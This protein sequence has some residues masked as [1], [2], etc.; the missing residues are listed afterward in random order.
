MSEFSLKERLIARFL[1]RFPGVKRYVKNV[2]V[3][4]N[5]YIYKKNYLS[6][7]HCKE[8][9]DINP[10]AANIDGED[11][12]GY[13][14]KLP[15]NKDGW[16]L[17]HQS[18]VS[19]RED[20]D[21]DKDI[22]IL[23]SNIYSGEIL[24]I[25]S[26]LSY[27]WQQGCR[28]QWIDDENILFNSVKENKYVC[29]LYS[30]KERKILNVF[31]YPVQDSYGE[32]FLSIDYSNLAKVTKDYGYF[33]N[34]IVQD[35]YAI[36][37]VDIKSGNSEILLDYKEIIN[38]DYIEE[39][40]GAFHT[41]NHIM[42]SPEGDK[43]IFIHRYYIDGVRYDRLMLYNLYTKELKVLV[44]DGMVSHCCWKTNDIVFGYMRV[45]NT[46][47]YYEIS[48]N[49]LETYFD[50]DINDLRVGDGHPSING[51]YLFFDTYPDKSR[52]QKIFYKLH[53]AKTPVL[54]LEVFSHPL[55]KESSRC[56]L[57]PRYDHRLGLLFFDSVFKGKRKQ[58]YINVKNL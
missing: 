30:I 31:N 16:V 53:S 43:F 25:G 58:Y 37:K 36:A 54:L 55:F 57:H 47:G 20:I 34:G 23:L 42:I 11:F 24:E 14:D 56:D 28:S 38:I 29:N 18:N 21:I 3:L 48:V 52:M 46:D 12:F 19:T 1:S 35:S 15:S 45:K 4:L 50:S 17:T 6:Y 13:Y 40:N 9:G 39:F 51:R 27:N 49:S 33:N 26:S 5:Y 41:V 44:N 2:Y 8:I 32:F 22:K 10:V 7:V